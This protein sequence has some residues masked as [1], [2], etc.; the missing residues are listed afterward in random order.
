MNGKNGSFLLRPMVWLRTRSIIKKIHQ[1]TPINLVHS[2]WYNE[3]AFLGEQMSKKLKVPHIST[4]MGQ[5][6]KKENSYLKFIRSKTMIRVTL[7]E[8]QKSVFESNSTYRIDAVIPFGISK[9]DSDLWSLQPQKR[10]VDLICV[11]SLIPL[12]QVHLFISIVA[13]IKSKLPNIKAVVV[14]DG[15]YRRVLE[16]QIIHFGL[17]ENVTL[18]GKLPRKECLSWMNQSKILVHTSEYE[19]QGYV[20]NEA[21]ALGCKVGTL[22]KGLEVHHPDFFIAND[23]QNLVNGLYHWLLNH[24]LVYEYQVPLSMEDTIEKYRLIY[25]S[26]TP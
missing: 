20:L 3:P 1:E 23:L 17:E 25:E 24:E 14:G 26:V 13:S 18:L 2:F 15:L 16:D 12:K 7:S 21:L 19:G 5:D 4:L 10:T 9:L 8:F 11:S 22:S 6:A